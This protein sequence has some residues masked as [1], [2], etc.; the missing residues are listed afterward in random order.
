S[1]EWQGL[2]VT[3][4]VDKPLTLWRFPIETVSLSESGF[5][6]VYQSSVVFLHSKVKI[7]KE[8]SLE[9]RLSIGRLR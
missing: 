2:R 7:E 3:V 5:E 9:F 6:R 8:Y 1:D 4:E